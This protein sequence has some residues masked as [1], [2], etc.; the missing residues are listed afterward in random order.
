MTDAERKRQDLNAKHMIEFIVTAIEAT[1]IGYKGIEAMVN[2]ISDFD[3]HL[4]EYAKV[5]VVFQINEKLN[6]TKYIAID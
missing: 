5:Q 3:W 4:S 6:P 1:T 2:L